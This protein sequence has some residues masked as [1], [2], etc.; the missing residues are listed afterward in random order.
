MKKKKTKKR[1][2]AKLARVSR[3]CRFTD[4]EGR[5]C[6]RPQEHKMHGPHTDDCLIL[7]ALHH[8]FTPPRRRYGSFTADPF[9]RT[10]MF[11]RT[12][13]MKY[14]RDKYG[15]ATIRIREL[16]ALDRG[17][18][19]QRLRQHVGEPIRREMPRK[20]DGTFAQIATDETL[21]V[22][23]RT[24]DGKATFYP[25]ATSDDEEIVT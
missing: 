18:R 15:T 1:K 22:I 19:G 5:K 16:I 8:E 6:R 14:L 12:S 11:L 9:V 24:P 20:D 17:Y 10:S 4:A 25:E 21:T 7:D 23:E 3:D 2:A 13:D